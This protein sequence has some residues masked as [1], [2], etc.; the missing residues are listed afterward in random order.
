[1]SDKD[2]IGGGPLSRKELEARLAEVEAELAE[3]RKRLDREVIER[4]WSGQALRECEERF[5]TVVETTS[6]S[7][8]VWDRGHNFVYA[9][10]AALDFYGLDRES[11]LGH[12]LDQ[13]L[14]SWPEHLTEMKL[15]LDQVF[16]TEERL[17]VGHRLERKGAPV[18][19]EATLSPVTD[20]LG[21]VNAVGMI[22]RDVTG[23]ERV[24]RAVRESEHRYR[25]V[26][27]NVGQAI[28]VVQDGAIRYANPATG[29]LIGLPADD[30]PG[31]G[32]ADFTHPEDLSM[33][34]RRF[35][36]QLRTRDHSR[37]F[38]FRVL[39]GRGRTRWVSGAAVVVDWNGR[40]GTLAFMTD[41]TELI[42]ARQ[43]AEAANR[44]K[45]EFL[46][47]ISHELRT[48][49]NA[50]IGLTSLVLD[51][52]LTDFQRDSLQSGLSEAARLMTTIEDVLLLTQVESGLVEISSQVMVM[53]EVIGRA[54]RKIEDRAREKGLTTAAGR[55][56]G[57]TP[58]LMSDVRLL[59][60]ILDKLLDN[61]L[62]FTD[63]GSIAVRAGL[64]P[65]HGKRAMD[66]VRVEVADTG[67]GLDP[68]LRA[69]I[70]KTLTQ[71]D[72]STTR[73]HGGVGLGLAV[74]LALARFLGGDVGVDSTPG[75]GSTFWFT[76]PYRPWQPE[77]E[78]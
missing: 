44:A 33:V 50:V 74:A 46:A 66:M 62:K 68:E 75:R 14:E 38:Q 64:I 72:S 65:G 67:I 22:S 77:E 26:V 45:D 1:M 27:E 18:Y 3:T 70:F 47:T 13:A 30:L 73:R 61:A 23:R 78:G 7:I 37:E 36:D 15:Q 17:A 20:G 28:V 49:M 5:A 2:D 59:G 8:A 39:D 40:R 63:Q 76:F 21:S 35:V 51:T 32:Y 71:A 4:R 11:I 56:G 57:E 31:R 41:V 60:L 10:R 19:R 42:R 16:E 48:P 55:L 43:A 24:L 9:N 54:M 6:D 58:P 34:R 29:T 12:G 69:H 25:L 52:D 53:D